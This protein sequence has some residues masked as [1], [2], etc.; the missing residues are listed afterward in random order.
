MTGLKKKIR[1]FGGISILAGIII[2][3]NHISFWQ[4]DIIMCAIFIGVIPARMALR[5]S[6]DFC[7]LV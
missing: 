3:Y 2:G 4:F 5:G 7:S 1:L 6:P